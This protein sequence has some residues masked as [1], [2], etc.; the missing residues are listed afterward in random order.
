MEEY[1][2]RRRR[3]TIRGGGEEEEEKEEESHHWMVINL[4][5]DPVTHSVYVCVYTHIQACV[6]MYID[7]PADLMT[8]PVQPS[9]SK[10]LQ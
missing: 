5:L 1:V 9:G 7:H 10:C 2:K 3:Q 6:H 8:T 4:F